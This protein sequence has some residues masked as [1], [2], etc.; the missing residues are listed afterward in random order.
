MNHQTYLSDTDLAQRY[1]VSRTTIWRWHRNNS[2]FPRV[3]SLSANTSRWRLADIET[4]E[5]TAFEKSA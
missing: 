5:S 3:I 1:G 2:D 4:W